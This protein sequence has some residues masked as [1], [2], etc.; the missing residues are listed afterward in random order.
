MARFDTIAV[1]LMASKPRGVLYIGVTSD[2]VDRVARHRAGEAS[3]FTK[4]YWCRRLVW[5]EVHADMRVAIQRETSLKRYLRD[6]K[7]NLIESENPSW[8]DLWNDIKPGV[9]YGVAPVTPGQLLR[10]EVCGGKPESRK[11]GSG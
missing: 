8:R 4:R 11:D 1:Y 2:L 7:I 6:W 3:S 10:G 9:A 5:Y